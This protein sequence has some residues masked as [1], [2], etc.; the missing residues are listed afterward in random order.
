MITVTG[1]GLLDM[2]SHFRPIPNVGFMMRTIDPIQDDPTGT[3]LDRLPFP[4]PSPF[5]TWGHYLAYKRKPGNFPVTDSFQ[6]G[7][8]RVQRTG[9][10]SY[11]LD[12]GYMV[13]YIT[14]QSDEM[15]FTSVVDFLSGEVVKPSTLR[16][17][18]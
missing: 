3:D 5:K 14:G 16:L 18:H 17:V 1:V 11:C 7:P 9:H 12:D 4:Q 15:A 2:F 10:R 8:I 6:Y 13:N